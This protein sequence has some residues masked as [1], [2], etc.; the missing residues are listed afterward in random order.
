MNNIQEIIEELKD[1]K[2]NAIKLVWKYE[3]VDRYFHGFFTGKAE[4]FN[5][6]IQKLELLLN[7]ETQT[8]VKKPDA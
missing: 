7:A 4:A 6:L 5:L 8:T 2:L 1:D 3:N